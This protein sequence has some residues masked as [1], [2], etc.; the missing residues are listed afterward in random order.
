MFDNSTVLSESN[1]PDWVIPVAAGVGGGLVLLLLIVAAIAI[2]VS[3][4]RKK[5]ASAGDANKKAA[6]DDEFASARGDVEMPI[7]GP[8]GEYGRFPPANPDANSA[9]GQSQFSNLN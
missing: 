7:M 1:S 2:I 4:V 3:Q 6:A 9:Y 5:R 8:N